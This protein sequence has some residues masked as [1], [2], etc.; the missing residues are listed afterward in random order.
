[1]FSKY[2]NFSSFD[3]QFLLI[4]TETQS[5]FHDGREKC[6]KL[7]TDSVHLRSQYVEFRERSENH[8][9]W[10]K[11]NKLARK[12]RSLWKTEKLS[13]V[14][15]GRAKK[16]AWHCSN[17]SRYGVGI[18]SLECHRRRLPVPLVF[19]KNVRHKSCWAIQELNKHYININSTILT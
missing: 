15:H 8:K 16:I 13:G 4:S 5:V 14:P 11:T 7:E 2:L 6:G 3:K 17:H 1:M 9:I 19:R 10:Q 18:M 12:P